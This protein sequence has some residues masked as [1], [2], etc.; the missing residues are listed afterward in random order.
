MFKKLF[1][2]AVFVG[3]IIASMD[4]GASGLSTGQKNR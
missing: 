3:E 1:K 2:A 4:S